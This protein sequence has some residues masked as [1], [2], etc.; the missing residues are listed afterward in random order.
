MNYTYELN[1]KKFMEINHKNV[2][3]QELINGKLDSTW[4]IEEIC[5]WK[6]W[7]DKLGDNYE[8]FVRCLEW[9]KTNHPELLL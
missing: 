8:S 4:S 7:Q 1:S 2:F 6:R 5:F 9:L 3:V